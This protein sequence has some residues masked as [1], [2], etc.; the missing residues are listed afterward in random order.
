MLSRLIPLLAVIF[1]SIPQTMA[2]PEGWCERTAPGKAG[3]CA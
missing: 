1:L 2:A 3:R